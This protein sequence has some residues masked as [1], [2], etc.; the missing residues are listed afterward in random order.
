MALSTYAEL[1]ASIAK[2]L[3]RDDQGDLIPDFIALAEG[4][5]NAVVRARQNTASVT[6]TFDDEGN[7]PVPAGFREPRTLQLVT[8]QKTPLVSV[9]PDRMDYLR[10]YSPDA[11]APRAYSIEGEVMRCHPIPSANTDA[12]LLFFRTI[13]ALSDAAPTNWV[14][15]GYAQAYL[16]GALTHGFARLDDTNNESKHR[17][18]F[19][20]MMARINDEGV[21][22]YGDDARPLPQ[23]AP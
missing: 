5:M 7:A 2:W 16:A 12:R 11:G 13:P 1:Q 3:V 14:L 17:A 23:V 10:T 19:E 6:V 22:L 4:D 15:A 8:G 9:S 20:A 21:D 18:K